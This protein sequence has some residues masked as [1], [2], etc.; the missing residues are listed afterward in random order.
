[1]GDCGDIEVVNV[2]ATGGLCREVDTR[3]VSRDSNFATVDY[4][5]NVRAAIFCFEG[6]N[7]VVVLYPSGKYILR[8]IK[9]VQSLE[10]VNNHFINGLEGMGIAVD[11]EDIMI[12]NVVCIGSLSEQLNLNQLLLELGLENTEY[13]PEQFPALVYRPTDGDWTFLIFSTGKITITGS[14]SEKTAC[15]EFRKLK[16]RIN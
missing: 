15:K 10:V 13:E 14:D 3:G 7:G 4:N 12:R 1:M 9:G 16:D 5:D 2:T 8:G 6:H 11:E